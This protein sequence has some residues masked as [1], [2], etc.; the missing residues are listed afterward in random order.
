M[1]VSKANNSS[2]GVVND[3]RPMQ[4]PIELLSCNDT[5]YNIEIGG[6]DSSSDT[7]DI[8]TN[9]KAVIIDYLDSK[10]PHVRAIGYT[11]QDALINANQ[12]SAIVQ[13]IIDTGSFENFVLKNGNGDII[14]ADTLGIG[15]LAYLNSLKINGSIIAL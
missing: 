10:R 6:L 15:C 8:K 3:R 2:F 7:T 5:A 13:N 4:V 14:T 9:I 11:A 12:L 1:V